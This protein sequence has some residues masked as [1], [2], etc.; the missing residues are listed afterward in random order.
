M[1]LVCLSFS[2]A[3]WSGEQFVDDDVQRF[4]CGH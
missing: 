4:A 3:L 1:K 2:R